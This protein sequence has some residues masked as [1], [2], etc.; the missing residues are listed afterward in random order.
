M[1]CPKLCLAGLLLCVVPVLAQDKDKDKSPDAG[2]DKPKAR[3]GVSRPATLESGPK[4]GQR[5]PGPF[6]PL[7]INGPDAGQKR[8]QVCKNG[9]RPVVLI[10]ARHADVPVTSL[11]KKVDQAIAKSETSM[12]GFAVFIGDPQALETPL[13]KLA[14]KEKLKEVTLAID[15]ER[16]PMKYQVAA[17]AEVTVILYSRYLVHANFAFGKGELKA[18]DISRIVAEIPKLGKAK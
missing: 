4:E 9:P 16:G 5:I 11:L 6:N 8:C 17:S 12:G 10:F 2:D 14:E 15:E 18:K 1:Y 7:I 3:V 13:T